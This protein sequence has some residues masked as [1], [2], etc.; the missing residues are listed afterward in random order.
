MAAERFGSR[1][2]GKDGEEDGDG[3]AGA[4]D[5]E[6][7]NRITGAFS[8]DQA[9]DLSKKLSSGSIPATISYL[10]TRTVGPSLGADSIHKGVLAAVA[11]MLAV[12]IFMLISVISM[13]QVEASRN[14]IR[15]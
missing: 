3:A 11:G 10:E 12:M 6:A 7:I 5:Y 1:R 8:E 9:A 14:K 15:G 4:Y 13:A 2:A